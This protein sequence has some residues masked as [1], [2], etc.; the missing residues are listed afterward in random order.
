MLL[1]LIYITSLLNGK[2]TD[3]IVLMKRD[4]ARVLNDLNSLEMPE[5]TYATTG[6]DMDYP[7]CERGPGPSCEV[8]VL[9]T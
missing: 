3:Y 8:T 6:T 4:L 1:S 7:D 5:S 9:P 2:V